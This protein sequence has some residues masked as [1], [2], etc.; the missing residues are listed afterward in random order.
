M[1]SAMTVRPQGASQ[2]GTDLIPSWL[3]FAVANSNRRC[4][5]RTDRRSAF[6]LE[7]LRNMRGISLSM[8]PFSGETPWESQMGEGKY[9]QLKLRSF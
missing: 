6:A 1:K 7:T 5:G 4:M 9:L 8:C 3:E 2:I